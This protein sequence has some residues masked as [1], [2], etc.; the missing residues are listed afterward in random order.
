M[1]PSESVVPLERVSNG[2]IGSSSSS[3]VFLDKYKGRIDSQ[4][5]VVE[6]SFDHHEEICEQNKQIQTRNIPQ[7]NARESTAAQA[8][9]LHSDEEVDAILKVI[10]LQI[11]CGKVT[12]R[13]CD[14]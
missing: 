1:E 11:S 13:A 2:R 4:C 8:K 5:D 12:F 6:D 9:K 3:H 14:N 10:T 7:I